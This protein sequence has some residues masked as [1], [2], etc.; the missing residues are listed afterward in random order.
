MQALA[1]FSLKLSII[2]IYV[3]RTKSLVARVRAALSLFVLAKFMRLAKEMLTFE[4]Y[5]TTVLSVNFS[6]L[7]NWVMQAYRSYFIEGRVSSSHTILCGRS[8]TVKS[9]DKL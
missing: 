2:L 5:C 9:A 8:C 7:K 3:Y 1:H 6:L 4:Y